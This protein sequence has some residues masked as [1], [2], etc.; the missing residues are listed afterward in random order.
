M[1][2]FVEVVAAARE[3]RACSLAVAAAEDE[4]V[5][6][7]VVAAQQQGIA[8]AILVGD[9]EKIR[10]LAAK[11]HFDLSPFRIV[12]EPVPA[13]AAL[14]AAAFVSRGEA[15][16]LM[17]G[18][19]S[20]ADFMRAVLD[21]E[22]GLR[23]GKN[24]ISHVAVMELSGFDRLLLL[25]DAAMNVSPDLGQKAQILQNA[26]GI[27]QALGVAVPKVACLAAVEVVNKEMT[28]CL[29]AAILAKMAER[30]QITGC[31]VD[32]PLALDNAVD[33]EAAAI[34]GINSPVAG[35]A[36]ILLVPELVAGNVLYKAATY[37]AK[38]KVAG[39]IVGARNPIVLTSR[40][41]SSES[42]LLSIA[43]AVVASRGKDIGCQ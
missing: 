22:V 5:L 7:A 39:I 32:G 35:R 28:V 31:I 29:E 10:Q 23:E 19:V 15:Q 33:P 20:T 17:K 2:A 9:Q 13:K 43:V 3:N 18:L 8:G 11:L 6:E 21:K 36:D 4:H 24:I 41:D 40:A 38:G 30:G 42:K 27:A 14:Q 37:F 34:K 26:V 16:V 1:N 25:T 12:H